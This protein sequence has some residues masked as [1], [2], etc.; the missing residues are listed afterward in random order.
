MTPSLRIRLFAGAGDRG[1]T[2]RR[3][4]GGVAAVDVDAA[5]GPTGIVTRE[6]LQRESD[7]AAGIVRKA[8]PR[9]DSALGAAADVVETATGILPASRSLKASTWSR[10]DHL[11][12]GFD[13]GCQCHASCGAAAPAVRRR[14][15]RKHPAIA[16]ASD[17]VAA[18]LIAAA[19]PLS[20]CAAEST[21][22]CAEK[23]ATSAAMPNMPPRKRPM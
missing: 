7:R 9:P 12:S 8:G 10:S 6:E 15:G 22:P 2:S 3:C 14:A 20:K 18:R 5:T 17:S 1:A 11:A 4:R 21:P 16:P 23:F 13:D 19:N